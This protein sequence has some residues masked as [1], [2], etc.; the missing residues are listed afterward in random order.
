MRVG[1][2]IQK[3]IWS[4]VVNART[5]RTPVALAV[6]LTV[7]VAVTWHVLWKL[8]LAAWPPPHPFESMSLGY[9]RDS[10][11]LVFAIL[12]VAPATKASGLVIGDIRRHWR[13]T[14]AICTFPILLALA[15]VPYLRS[16]RCHGPHRRRRYRAEG[17]E[18]VAPTVL[19]RVA[20]VADMLVSALVRVL[21][22]PWRRRSA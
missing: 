5:P 18:A 10:I 7:S 22:T 2:R 16:L 1:T 9:W 15:A 12:L 19:A 11:T 8:A 14:L 13:S 21:V 20:T 17:A 6:V 3:V 4:A